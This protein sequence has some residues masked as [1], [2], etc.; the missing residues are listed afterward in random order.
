MSDEPIPVKKKSP[1][2]STP[3]T[4][5]PRSTL[6][7]PGRYAGAGKLPTVTT[8]AELAAQDMNDVRLIGTYVELDARMNPAPPPQYDGHAAIRLADGT[9]VTLFPTWHRDARRPVAEIQQLKDKQVEVAGMVF[10]EAPASPRGGA[11]LN[12]PCIM[13]IKGL[14][15]K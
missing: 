11:S 2:A 10:A 1:T 8:R 14:W 6:A 5:A 3:S 15:A 7:L 9:L 13:D 12:A 4:G